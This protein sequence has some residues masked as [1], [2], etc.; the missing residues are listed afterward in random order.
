MEPTHQPQ[1]FNPG[2]KGWHFPHLQHSQITC[3][4]EGLSYCN[5]RNW[6]TGLWLSGFTKLKKMRGKDIS[7]PF[8]FIIRLTLY[9]TYVDQGLW[10]VS[11]QKSEL[12]SKRT[13][14][15]GSGLGY[16]LVPLILSSLILFRNSYFENSISP[17]LWAKQQQQKKPDLIS[18]LSHFIY[19]MPR[20]YALVIALINK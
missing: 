1:L 8:E 5:T 16:K 6:A 14:I 11:V 20:Q 10:L 7:S 13:L 19:K 9:V 17:S 18:L 15:F 3:I 12:H 2:L 4:F